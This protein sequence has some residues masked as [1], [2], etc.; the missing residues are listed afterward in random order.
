VPCILRLFFSTLDPPCFGRAYLTQILI[1]WNAVNCNGRVHIRAIIFI[2]TS[3]SGDSTLEFQGPLSHYVFRHRLVYSNY[4]VF[5]TYVP[6]YETYLSI[7]VK[8]N[9]NSVELRF[10]HN[11]VIT[12]IHPVDGALVLVH[13]GL[14]KHST[15]PTQK[16]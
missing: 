4:L 12:G 11:W 3:N 10:I 8:P 2:L 14:F 16:Q 5:Y 15:R 13:C 6:I 9:T 7:K 1:F